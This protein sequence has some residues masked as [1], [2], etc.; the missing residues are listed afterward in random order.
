MRDEAAGD[1]LVS[2]NGCLQRRTSKPA[3]QHS[4]IGQSDPW[5]QT[6]CS[7]GQSVHGATWIWTLLSPITLRLHCTMYAARHF[8]VDTGFEE[9]VESRVVVTDK[10]SVGIAKRNCQPELQGGETCF[11]HEPHP[12]SAVLQD[13]R[14]SVFP[15]VAGSMRGS[16]TMHT[17]GPEPVLLLLR[18]RCKAKQTLKACSRTRSQL[19]AEGLM[20]WRS[21]LLLALRSGKHSI[22]LSTNAAVR[23]T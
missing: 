17:C 4:L 14:P 15:E 22:R 2:T 5:N 8:T 1:S 6:L 7:F 21:A 20:V 13:S 9:D 16:S 11:R 10:G 19:G 23:S 3:T 18:T 12:L